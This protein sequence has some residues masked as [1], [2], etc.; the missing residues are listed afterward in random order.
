MRSCETWIE[1]LLDVI[2]RNEM[3]LQNRVDP[4]GRLQAV[5]ARGSLLGNRGK[6]HDEYREIVSQSERRAWVT[7]ELDFNGRHRAVFGAKTY[8]ELFFLDEAT[9][10]AAGHRPCA[11]CRRDRYNDFKS[12][13]LAA[14]GAA[15]PSVTSIAELD[16]ALHA[17]RIDRND[18][19]VTY[20]A[21]FSSLPLGTFVDIN[22]EALLLWRRGL[23]RWSFFGYSSSSARP[24]PQTPVRVLTPKSVVRTLALGFVPSVHQSA[25][26]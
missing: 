5:S 13:W 1:I 24:S 3:T 4:W 21:P 6:L 8:S 17:E 10:L 19:K 18:A 16:K 22:G 2:I 25:S 14:N 11:T 20:D 26:V 12:K 9:A 23:K 15:M 7:C